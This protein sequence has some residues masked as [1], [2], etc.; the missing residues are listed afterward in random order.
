MRFVYEGDPPAQEKAKVTTDA[1]YCC[2]K[3]PMV[4]R[5]VVNPDDRGIANVVVYL[6]LG[7]GV[8]APT[9]HPSYEATAES[10][11]ELD[12]EWCRFDPHIRTVRTSQTL[13]INNKDAISHNTNAPLATQFNEMIPVDGHIDKKIT[14]PERVPVPVSCNIH[15]W[16][17]GYLVVQDHPYVAVSDANGQ[18]NLQNLPAGEWT[19][20]VW[21]EEPGYVTRAKLNGSDVQWD[22]GRFTCAI[23]V[24]G[25]D[26]GEVTLSPNLFAASS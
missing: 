24:G 22:L 17:K 14:E 19:F 7:R 15:P 6:Y 9:P 4:E 20:Q 10:V 18:V 11:V 16:M 3:P 1:D 5:L 25:N 2:K 8:T 12:N 26:L 21:H 13:R 23:N